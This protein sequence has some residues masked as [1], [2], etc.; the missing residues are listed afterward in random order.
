M[1]VPE[2]F[3]M[4]KSRPDNGFDDE[5]VQHRAKVFESLSWH[6]DPGL[7]DIGR[8]LARGEFAPYQLLNVPRYVEVLQ[9]G[10]AGLNGMSDDDLRRRIFGA[11]SRNRRVDDDPDDREG[12]VPAVRR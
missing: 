6:S 9:R 12:G 5:L 10:A 3:A 1:N 8:R 2:G 7:A 11:P 4:P